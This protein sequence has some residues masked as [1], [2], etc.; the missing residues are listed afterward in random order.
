VCREE[1]KKTKKKAGDIVDPKKN[2][3]FVSEKVG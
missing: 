3:R 2:T 1:E